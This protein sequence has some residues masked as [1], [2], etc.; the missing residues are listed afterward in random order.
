M[1]GRIAAMDLRVSAVLSES[2]IWVNLGNLWADSD[3]FVFSVSLRFSEM[4]GSGSICVICGQ[5]GMGGRNNDN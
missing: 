1:I 2:Q 5:A 4:V 3:G